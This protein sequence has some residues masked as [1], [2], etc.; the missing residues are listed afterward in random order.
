MRPHAGGSPA[1]S[2]L[3]HQKVRRLAQ[4]TGTPV[5]TFAEDVAASGGYVLWLFCACISGAITQ[6]V[7]VHS[8][9]VCLVMSPSDLRSICGLVGY[10]QRADHVHPAIML[11]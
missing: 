10:R 6:A 2:E 3:I 4:Q 5:F 8:R 11:G 7:Q 1:Q 9:D